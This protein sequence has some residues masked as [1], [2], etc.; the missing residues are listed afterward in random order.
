MEVEISREI[1]LEQVLGDRKNT[2]GLLANRFVLTSSDVDSRCTIRP[3]YLSSAVPPLH[4]PHHIS[5][6]DD[7]FL[8]GAVEG[9]SRGDPTPPCSSGFDLHRSSPQQLC[10]VT[11][12][13]DGENVG[14]DEAA[15]EDIPDESKTEF[16]AKDPGS[17]T[18]QMLELAR[19]GR[20]RSKLRGLAG[21]P[22]GQTRSHVSITRASKLR[23]ELFDQEI[24]REEKEALE[25]FKRQ[26]RESVLQS[27]TD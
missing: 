27:S 4:H 17:D 20:L 13:F 10:V 1:A 3:L 21:Q 9:C 16:G 24:Q 12:R 14:A 23:R 26:L 18:K 6:K 22:D 8:F 2:S 25:E 15:K 11:R 7:T 5:L 19:Q